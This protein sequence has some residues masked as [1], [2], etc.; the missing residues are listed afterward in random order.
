MEAVIFL[1]VLDFNL[2]LR[3]DNISTKLLKSY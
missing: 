1:I 2:E 3:S